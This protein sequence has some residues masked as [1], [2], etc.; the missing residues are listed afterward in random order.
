MAAPQLSKGASIQTW[1][2]MT[3][4]VSVDLGDAAILANGSN[5]LVPAINVT[6]SEVGNLATLDTTDQTSLVA[7]LNETQKL[8]VVLGIV[9]TTPLN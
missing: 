3:N 2:E 7:A 9:L 5:I 1:V 6:N 8:A 4:E